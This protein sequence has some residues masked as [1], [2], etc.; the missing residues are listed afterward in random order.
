MMAR[1]LAIG[2]LLTA[3][4]C[5]GRPN[6]SVQL[7]GA[8]DGVRKDI[9]A[10]SIVPRVTSACPGE[11][12]TATYIARL[13]DNSSVRLSGDELSTLVRAG[14]GADPFPDG[15]WQT[16][17]DPMQSIRS[18]F[19][20]TATL[21]GNDEVRADTVVAPMYECSRTQLTLPISDRFNHTT[22]HVRLGTF[23][24]PFHDSVVVVAIELPTTSYIFTVL[25]PKQIH[26]GAIQ[27][28]AAGKSGRDGRPGRAGAAGSSCSSGDRGEDGEDGEAGEAGGQV[29]L[30]VEAESPW[31]ESIV[32]V[33][34]PGG[35]GGRA[36][37]GGRGG[38]AGSTSAGS[39]SGSGSGRCTARP[40][41]SGRP[42]HAGANGNPGPTS[43]TSYVIASLLWRGSPVWA[44]PAARRAF[45]ALDQF[46]ATRR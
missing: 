20:L 24:T 34:N 6:A 21:K 36:G 23:T 46:S 16:S 2:A 32:S 38:A 8:G 43:K 37:S 30:I 29:D 41:P 13:T 35:A 42:G 45:E 11:R 19:H 27:I 5:G 22:A 3:V 7:A 10:L 40:G 28:V 14:V 17:H 39:P 25:G 44:D 18:G 33:S 15:S 31:L 4:A 1:A 26:A 9:R 12:I